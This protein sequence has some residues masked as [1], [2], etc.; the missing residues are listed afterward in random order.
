M[1]KSK[2]EGRMIHMSGA[3]YAGAR[4]QVGPE[5]DG[6]PGKVGDLVFWSANSRAPWWIVEWQPDNGEVFA[7]VNAAGDIGVAGPEALTRNFRNA[8]VR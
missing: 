4:L 2:L 8:G 7:I 5:I 1:A 6:L 3:G